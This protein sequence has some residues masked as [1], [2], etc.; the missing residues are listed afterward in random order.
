MAFEANHKSAIGTAI[1]NQFSEIRLPC[2]S[3]GFTQACR[4]LDSRFLP[5]FQ[6]YPTCSVPE[7]VPNFGLVIFK[8]DHSG[9]APL[10][11]F[12]SFCLR[13]ES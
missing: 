13:T 7:T 2:R 4:D 8:D 11:K 3:C 9:Q 6:A 10:P 5:A 12:H 1:E